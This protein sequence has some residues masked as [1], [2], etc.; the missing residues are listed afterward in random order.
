MPNIAT[1]PV[2]TKRCAI[3][4]RKSTDRGLDMP[5]NSLESQRE[6]CRAYIKSQAHRNWYETTANYDDGGYSGGTLERP[7]LKQ[8]ISDVEAGRVDIIVVYKIDRLTRSLLDFVRLADV[9]EQHGA[10]FISVTQAFDTSDSMGRLIL[11]V[12][13]TFA[14]FERELMSD[15]VRDKKAAMRRKG[16]FTGGLPPFG[17]LLGSGGKLLLDPERSELVREIFERFPKTSA[18]RE[19]VDDLRNRACITRCWRSKNGRH[20]GGQPITTSVLDQILR[21]PIYTGHIV[22]RGEWLKAEIEPIISREQWDSVQAERLRRMPFRNPDRDFLSGI[23]HDEYGRRMRILTCGPGR[24]NQGRYYRAESAGWSRGTELKRILVSADK[25]ERLTRSA[26]TAL[27]FDRKLLIEAVLSLGSYSLETDA[28]LQKGRRAARRVVDMN[29]AAFRRLMLA[30]VPRAEV[31]GSELRLYISCFELVQLLA[32]NGAGIFGKSTMTPKSVGD[33]VYLLRAPA[34]L[35][36]GKKTFA[37]PLRPCFQHSATP[38]PWLVA[39]IERAA[40]LRQFALSNRSMTVSELAKA[41]RM[42]PS[43]FARFI[44]VNYLAPDIQAAIVD[45]TQPERLTQHDLIYGPLPLDWEQQRHL[46][47]FF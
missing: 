7:A 42:S 40:E 27:L 14:Q 11:N 20:H 16:L 12:L 45:G 4:A 18:R 38:K 15:R 2:S 33:R 6:I 21:N 30:L 31:T 28:L 13:L 39:T 34:T 32:W 24:T 47:G 41:K 10:S 43:L 17:Y 36:C 19:L 3:Y 26:V 23:L 46:L 1:A 25:A 22:H 9:L 37:V 44:R 29:G 35:A 5:V 8:L